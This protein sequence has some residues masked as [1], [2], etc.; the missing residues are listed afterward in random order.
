MPTVQGMTATLPEYVIAREL[1]RMG[2]DYEFQYQAL[3]LP[4]QKGSARADFYLP[5]YSL[6]I[7]VLGNY[8]HSDSSTKVKDKFQAS[9]LASRSIKT[10]GIDETDA[11]ANPKYYIEQALLGIDH[12]TLVSR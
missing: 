3:G 12:S 5:M 8:W 4:Q 1:D 10:I 6:I 9:T 2:I 11:E 7:S